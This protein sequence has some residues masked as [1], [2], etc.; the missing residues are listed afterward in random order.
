MWVSASRVDRNW[1]NGKLTVQ[2]QERQAVASYTSN[3]GSLQFF[4]AK[5]EDFQSP[6]SYQGIPS[7]NL[8]ISSANSKRAVADLLVLL[9][10]EL[11]SRAKT[12]TVT[13]SGE[14]EMELTLTSQRKGKIKWGTATD[15]PLKVSV[16]QKLLTL[17]ENSKAI[18]FDLSNPLS[19]ITK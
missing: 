11:L 2:I 8:A 3:D 1:F 5:G 16:Y 4:D 14:I 6:L 15:I 17:T 13:T 9:P 18:V 10:K 19:P 7:I 12:F